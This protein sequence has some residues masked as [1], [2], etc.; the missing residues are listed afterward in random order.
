MSRGYRKN[1]GR[2]LCVLT[3]FGLLAVAAPGCGEASGK[4]EEG[5][6]KVPASVQESNKNM[7]NFMKSQVATKRKK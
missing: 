4:K 6:N 2:A 1:S 5:L 3:V 7:E